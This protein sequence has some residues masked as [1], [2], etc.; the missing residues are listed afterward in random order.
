MLRRLGVFGRPRAALAGVPPSAAADGEP[1]LQ[2]EARLGR[3]GRQGLDRDRRRRRRRPPARNAT[4][5]N[6]VVPGYENEP[7]L[8][9]L[10]SGRVEI[11]VNSPAKYL[12]EERYGGVKVPRG[13][14]KAKP[15][16]QLVAQGGGYAW[17]DHRIHWMSTE[18]AA[19]G[20]GGRRQAGRRYSTGSCRSSVGGERVKASGTLW[21]VPTGQR[22]KPMR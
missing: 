5:K 15:Q 9:F 7:Y 13:D 2:L 10:T 16:W 8:R 1:Q 6:V 12:N 19:A 17:H 11:N 20:Q 14:A 3:S 18:Q 21:W 4:G 22:R